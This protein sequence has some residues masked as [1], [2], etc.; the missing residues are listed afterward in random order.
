LHA[1]ALAALVTLASS[2]YPLQASDR[3]ST[4][5]VLVAEGERTE[6]DLKEFLPGTKWLMYNWKDRVIEFRKDGKFE[7]EDWK[8]QGITAEWSVTGVDQVTVRVTSQKF[9]NLTAV[10]NFD[11]DRTSF[12]GH[13]LD[14]KREVTK[15]PRISPPVRNDDQ[16][17]KL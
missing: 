3:S 7:L 2:V 12:T 13:D 8:R 1:A 10:F 5:T 11:R 14:K 9:R 6:R 16:D 15:S 4:P 17:I